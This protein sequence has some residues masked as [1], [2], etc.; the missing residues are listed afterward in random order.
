MHHGIDLRVIGPQLAQEH[1]YAFAV[2][3]ERLRVD[4]EGD[5]TCEARMFFA[6]A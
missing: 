2:G 4:V 5:T 6:V 1:R 3:G